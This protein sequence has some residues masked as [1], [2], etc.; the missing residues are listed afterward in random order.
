MGGVHRLHRLVPG[1]RRLVKLQFGLERLYERTEYPYLAVLG[2]ML[3]FSLGSSY[4]GGCYAIAVAYFGLSGLMLL[5]V[6]WS[7]LEYGA[8][9]G[10]VLA[11]MGWHLRRLGREAGPAGKAGKI[12][13]NGTPT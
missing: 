10:A 13:A 2:G 6:R 5:D 7:I 4:W 11:L 3:F 8:M 9:W 1:P 12:S